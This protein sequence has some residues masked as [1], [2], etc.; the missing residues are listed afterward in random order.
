MADLG[1][2]EGGMHHRVK[3]IRARIGLQRQPGGV[4]G[5]IVEPD[6]DLGLLGRGCV[7]RRS[8]S[9]EVDVRAVVAQERPGPTVQAGFTEEAE[10]RTPVTLAHQHHTTLFHEVGCG[11]AQRAASS[12]GGHRLGAQAS[13]KSRA[14]RSQGEFNEQ[15]VEFG[16]P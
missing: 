11:Q 12:G 6:Q 14:F 10:V 1:V 15:V 3:H 5:R 7:Q 8:E 13:Q 16:Q 2:F 4:V 9:L